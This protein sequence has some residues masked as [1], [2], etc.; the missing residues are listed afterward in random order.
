M[1]D[2]HRHSAAHGHNRYYQYT[3]TNPS[4]QPLE[5]DVGALVSQVEVMLRRRRA[6]DMLTTRWPLWRLLDRLSAAHL[7]NVS[8]STA[9]FWMHVFP[10]R[11]RSDGLI[12]NRIRGTQS[13]YCLQLFQDEVLRIAGD[14]PGKVLRLVDAGPHIGDCLLW[15]SAVLQDRVE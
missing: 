4:N 8:A 14:R 7:V 6:W 10:H 11:V 5:G 9:W 12:S 15:A 13:A 1:A 3:S 2:K